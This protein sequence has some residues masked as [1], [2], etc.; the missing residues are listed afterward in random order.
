[1]FPWI[2]NHER[3]DNWEPCDEEAEETS[4]PLSEESEDDGDD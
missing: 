4:G 3:W 2:A 1:M